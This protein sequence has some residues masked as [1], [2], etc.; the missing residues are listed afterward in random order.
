MS[1]NQGPWNHIGFLRKI[2]LFRKEIR[3]GR[4]FEF[5]SHFNSQEVC[6]EQMFLINT[7]DQIIARL[8]DVTTTLRPCRCRED[9]GKRPD[10]GV[11]KPPKLWNSK[12]FAIDLPPAI[13][14]NLLRL[15]FLYMAYFG[16]LPFAA[17]VTKEG[18]SGCM[19][20]G[21]AAL[22]AKAWEP[23]RGA[24]DGVGWDSLSS[25]NPWLF[26]VYRGFILPSPSRMEC[27][28]FWTLLKH[29]EIWFERGKADDL[30]LGGKIIQWRSRELE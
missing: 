2:D 15:L 8:Q 23:P 17:T 27:H 18:P 29:S 1:Q 19:A 13:F 4:N 20:D 30:L 16:M 3:M 6:A 11:S 24:G 28:K 12:T 21:R 10:S 7:S 25:P 14:M 26:A 5:H 22:A 9:M